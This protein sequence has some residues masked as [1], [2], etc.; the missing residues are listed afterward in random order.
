[1]YY[2]MDHPVISD[3]C[4]DEIVRRLGERWEDLEHP[5]KHLIDRGL[6]KSGFYLQYPERV[7]WAALCLLEE[8]TLSP[9]PAEV[10]A[11][12]ELHVGR[13]GAAGAGT[14]GM[15]ESGDLEGA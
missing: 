7:R 3:S 10:G 8:F 6:L 15:A 2:V 4:F 5:H 11:A 9:I 12:G 13:K 1:M 14:A